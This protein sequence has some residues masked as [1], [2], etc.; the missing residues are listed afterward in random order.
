MIALLLPE[1]YKQ[2]VAHRD[3]CSANLLLR[4][5]FRLVIADFGVSA[6]LDEND[7]NNCSQDAKVNMFADDL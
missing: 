4:S 1:P 7:A 5:D 6:I 2:A 3:I